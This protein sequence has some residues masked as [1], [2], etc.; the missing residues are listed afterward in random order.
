VPKAVRTNWYYILLSLVGGPRHGQAIAREVERITDGRLRLWP[1][2]L[3]S[4][5]DAMLDHGWLEEIRDDSRRPDM[6]ERRRYFALTRSGHSSLAEETQRLEDLVRI[7][8]T[9]RRRESR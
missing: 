3:Y 2:T 6:N 7:A 9:V 8:R 4:A 1:A 5:L